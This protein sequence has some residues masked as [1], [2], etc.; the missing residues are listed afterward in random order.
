MHTTPYE[1]LADALDR[2]PNGFPRTPSNV[3]LELLQ[4]IFT[5]DEAKLA[6]LLS[7]KM[8]PLAEI[9]ASA[10][11]PVEE[12]GARLKE[13]AQKRL[14]WFEP[15][16]VEPRF[17][18]APFVVGIYE[19]QVNSMDGELARLVEAYLADGGA[20]GI[21]SYDPA[22]HRVIPARG[23]TGDWVLSYDD[24]KKILLKAKSFAVQDCICRVQQSHIGRKC[25]HPI[26]NC[27]VF[28]SGE[29]TPGFDMI[30]Q[31][32]ALSILD[33]TEEIG[34]VHTV[35]NVTEGIGYICNC[36]G[37]CCAVLRGVTEWGIEKSVAYANYYA[38]IDQE[39]CTGCETCHDRCQ[40]D[41]IISNS[42][43]S[44]VVR[45][46]CIG[47]GLCVTTCPSQA[48]ELKLK[49]KAEIVDPPKDYP[50]WEKMRLQS[51]GME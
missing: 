28:N 35:S 23:A 4:R 12:A 13:M 30:S 21:M 25:D 6:G 33:K 2:L 1:K 47:C 10:G 11:L 3:E 50:T 51:R 31:E 37:C 24:V 45:K 42:D 16:P 17:R 29:G 22:I 14:L 7:G 19:A 15:D 46:S 27:M 38:V 40:V 36:C 44:E 20:A 34:L 43:A 32:E 48:I 5:E 49:P 39:E 18:L 8:E 26:R 41:A 9:A